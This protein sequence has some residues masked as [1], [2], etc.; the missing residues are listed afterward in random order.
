MMSVSKAIHYSRA[1]NRSR[2]SG[3]TSNG[4]HWKSH[5]VL[6]C[7]FEYVSFWERSFRKQLN[8]CRFVSSSIK[9]TLEAGGIL[10]IRRSDVWH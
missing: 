8:S 5:I 2:F 3:C 7:R 10:R 4:K 6:L 9:N 1:E